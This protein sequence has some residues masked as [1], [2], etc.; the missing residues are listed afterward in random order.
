MVDFECGKKVVMY[1]DVI[2]CILDEKEWFYFFVV[3][4]FIIGCFY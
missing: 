3:F 4:Y 2:E 1:F